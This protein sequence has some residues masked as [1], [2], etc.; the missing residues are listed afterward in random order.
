MN[1]N[2][3]V[4][5][6]LVDVLTI[7]LAPTFKE[8]IAGFDNNKELCIENGYLPILFSNDVPDTWN[9]FSEENGMI[10]VNIFTPDFNLYKSRVVSLIR[11]KYSSDDEQ[12]ILRK[13]FS[14]ISS[15]EFRLYNEFCESC[16]KKAKLEQVLLV[17]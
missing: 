4:F 7:E 9:T 16:K 13:A 6:K 10:K 15:D 11:E 12:S 3:Q 17:R 14:G 5:A 8:G 1:L 2:K